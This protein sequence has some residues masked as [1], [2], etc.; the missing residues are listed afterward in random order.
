MK[1]RIEIRGVITSARLD[2]PWFESFISKGMITPESRIRAAI[3][4]AGPE[5]E[6]YINSYGGDVLAGNEMIVAL[7]TAMAA[8]KKVEIVV[9]A[10]AFSMAANMI[11]MLPG[12]AKISAFSNSRIGYHGAYTCSCGGEGA[13][14]DSAEMLAGINAQVISAIKSKGGIKA[15]VE[16][17]FQEGRIKFLT[18]D[19]ALKMKIIDSIIDKADTPV[20]S[21]GQEAADKLVADGINIAAFGDEHIE[22]ISLEEPKADMS[23]DIMAEFLARYN[24]FLTAAKK[25]AM[26]LVVTDVEAEIPERL[27]KLQAAKD[28]EISALKAEHETM[29][30]GVKAS[31][32]D[33]LKALTQSHEA[34]VNDLTSKH[35]LATKELG[36]ATASLST[37]KA[38]FE[39]TKATLDTTVKQL[40]EVKAAYATLTGEVLAKGDTFATFE[41]ASA[42]L[43]YVVARQQC[44]DL[45]AS[46]MAEQKAKNK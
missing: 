30:T 25:P 12:A 36:E 28:K 14:K 27:S 34:I 8:G 40:T 11:V 22:A 13:H 16:E 38:E 1:T 18:A 3:A 20:E 37:V 43:G 15:N 4:A 7:K 42:K 26:K 17:W 29:L 10:M 41:A 24:S 44:P 32:E 39:T 23:D 6:L 45:F 46:Y 21:L 5:I 2:D 33:A 9:G 19:Q 31:H 35:A